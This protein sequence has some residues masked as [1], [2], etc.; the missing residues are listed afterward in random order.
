[1]EK[2]PDA[3]EILDKSK[4]TLSSQVASLKILPGKAS[5]LHLSDPAL[6]IG[7]VTAPPL[8]KILYLNV[9]DDF[10]SSLSFVEFPLIS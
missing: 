4:A 1:V 6:P 7:S 10:G 5:R 9:Q 2:R 3:L 8:S